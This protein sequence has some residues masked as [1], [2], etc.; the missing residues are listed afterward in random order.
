MSIKYINDPS[1]LD[2]L[3][4]Q[5]WSGPGASEQKFNTGNS[6]NFQLD[7]KEFTFIP[8]DVINKGFTDGNTQYYF[9]DLLKKGNLDT[10]KTKGQTVDLNGVSW[11]GDFLKDTM[12]RNTTGVLIPTE[13]ANKVMGTLKSYE[14]G[15]TYGKKDNIPKTAITGLAQTKKGDFVYQ[16]EIPE[17]KYPVG[18]TKWAYN[19]IDGDG[20]IRSGAQA[21]PKSSGGFLGKVAKVVDKV[22][23]VA[24]AFVPG[25]GP[26]LS[27]AY[28]SGSVIGKG[29]S[30]EDAFKA[31]AISYGASTLGAEV[32]GQLGGETTQVFDDGSVLVTN[33]AGQAVSGTDALGKTFSVTD[34][35]GVYADG[36]PLGGTPVKN[37]GGNSLVK[38][39]SQV[40]DDGSTLLSDSAGN[41]ISGTDSTNKPFTVT[42]GVGKYD[43][44]TLLGGT[45]EKTFGGQ[46]ADKEDVDK[47]L[48]YNA[49]TA[50]AGLSEAEK[51]KKL[52]DALTTEQ[53]KSNFD[54]YMLVKGLTQ[55]QQD[56]NIGYNMNQNPFT[57]TQQLPIQGNAGQMT[58][59]P[60]DV[61][62]QK[63][64]MAALLRNL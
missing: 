38:P 40:F 16:N 6:I 20:T 18:G 5:Y 61:T 41:P 59:T 24:L 8:T 52:A 43:D 60:L 63:R 36:S 53:P 56:V 54:P 58:A 14:I 3:Q 4:Y 34:G 32:G 15:S 19:Y 23:P 22:A 35:V 33:S 29:G 17:G 21:A 55:G 27:A 48:N 30:I 49:A 7:G 47:L 64:N 11:Y 2:S 62:D 12:G 1:Q 13:E 10:L 9:S 25:I 37:F 39:T 45:P 46:L 26:A 31:G 50:T 51:A 57:F 28:S 44:G 42:D